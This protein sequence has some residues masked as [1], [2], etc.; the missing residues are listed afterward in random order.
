MT[1][2][3]ARRPGAVRGARDPARAPAHAGLDRPGDGR[4]HLAAGAARG[5]LVPARAA[6]ASCT[7]SA[8]SSR[9]TGWCRPATWRCGGHAWSG[10]GVDRDGRVDGRA[11]RCSPRAPTGATRGGC[12]E[13]PRIGG[14]MRSARA[15]GRVPPMI[16]NDKSLPHRPG[17]RMLACVL[18][19]AAPR[20][21]LLA[22]AL[23]GRDR[24]PGRE[25]RRISNSS[26][27]AARSRR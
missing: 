6:T 21:A 27:R 9:P 12:S 5:R 10:K 15:D 4:R 13:D 14:S 11:G 19:C 20:R 7:T 23:A 24:L 8:S 2:A 1:G 17:S 3:D 18:A 26:S 22:T 16:T 25:L